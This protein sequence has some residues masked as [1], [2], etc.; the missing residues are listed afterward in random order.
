[1]SAVRKTVSKAKKPKAARTEMK[2]AN[3]M[4]ARIRRESIIAVSMLR[5]SWIVTLHMVKNGKEG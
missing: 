3:C 5:Q 2:A 4:L 1:M